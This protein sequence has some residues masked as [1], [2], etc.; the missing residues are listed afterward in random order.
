MGGPLRLL[1]SKGGPRRCRFLDVEDPAP[2]GGGNIALGM[3]MLAEC[4]RGKHWKEKL[5]PV[6]RGE[7]TGIGGRYLLSYI[8]RVYRVAACISFVLHPV[9]LARSNVILRDREV[10]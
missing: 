1:F 8:K 2:L 7:G 5:L 6:S 4:L 9:V 3:K 10:A